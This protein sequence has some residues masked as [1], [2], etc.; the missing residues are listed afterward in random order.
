MK[1]WGWCH[2]LSDFRSG[3]TCKKSCSSLL[4]VNAVT[5]LHRAVYTMCRTLIPELKSNFNLLY[6]LYLSSSD[7]KYQSHYFLK[8]LSAEFKLNVFMNILV[9]FFL[10]CDNYKLTT[11]QQRA[12]SLQS[13]WMTRN[14]VFLK[15]SERLVILTTVLCSACAYFL[16]KICV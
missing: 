10:L 7:Q 2:P 16:K 13:V 8:R 11:S 6:Y 12:P 1:C 14:I 15:L 9:F 3:W 4:C 5:V